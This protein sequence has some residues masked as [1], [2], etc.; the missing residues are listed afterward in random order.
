MHLLKS[1][2]KKI[3][4]NQFSA[5]TEAIRLRTLPLAIASPVLGSFFALSENSFRWDVFL[6]A[7]TTTLLLQILSN[8]A[9]DYGDFK[10]GADNSERIG[11]RRL[12]QSGIISPQ[13]MKRA[14]L[15]TILL[16]LVSGL[17]LIF[18]GTQGD[19]QMTKLFFILLGFGAIAAAITY[20]MGKNP[21]GYKGLGDVFVFLFFGLTGVLGTY[22]LHTA[23]INLWLVLPAASVGLLSVG[24]LNLNNLRDYESDKK[25]NKRTMVVLL[26]SSKAKIYHLLLVSGSL[27]TGLLYILFNFH[28]GFQFLFVFIIPMMVNNIMTVFKNPSPIELYPELRKLAIITLL[29]ALSFGL[30]EIL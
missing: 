7:A 1:I 25:A 5:W 19:G 27:V 14:V 6:L 8:L 21:Y 26:G 28:S 15:I 30:G 9:N 23:N 22:Y 12:V 17:A 16:A 13:L 11:P 4:M 29:F 10:T 24:V 20:T 3:S 18:T 2:A